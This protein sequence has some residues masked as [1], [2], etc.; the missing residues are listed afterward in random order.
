[1]AILINDNLLHCSNPTCNSVEFEKVTIKA[2]N[3]K[4]E[5]KEF[6]KPIL[7]EVNNRILLKCIECGTII[8]ADEYDLRELKQD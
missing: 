4:A 8:N 1:M 2:F 5:N 7:L 6:S 3:K